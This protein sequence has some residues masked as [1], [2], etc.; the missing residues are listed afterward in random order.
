MVVLATTATLTIGG[1]AMAALVRTPPVQRVVVTTSGS[2][3]QPQA[4]S[5]PPSG[6]PTDRVTGPTAH[7]SLPSPDPTPLAQPGGTQLQDGPLRSSSAIDAHSNVYWAQSNVTLTNTQ[8][9]TA[10]TVQL[11]IAQTGS[12]RSTGSWQTLPGSDFTVT[13]QQQNGVLTYRWTLL[14]GHTVPAG[15]HIF[16]GQYN[17]ATGRRN[18]GQDTYRADALAGRQTLQVWGGFPATP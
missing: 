8:P 12:V 6:G 7:P 11:Q 17:H 3:S 1:F 10:L 4:S 14:A 16:A 2:P 18:T 9:L 15:Q 5:A 13:V